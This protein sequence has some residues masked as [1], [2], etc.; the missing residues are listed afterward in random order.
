MKYIKLFEHFDKYDFKKYDDEQDN[1]EDIWISVSED[2]YPLS[3]DDFD[4]IIKNTQLGFKYITDRHPDKDKA[5]YNGLFSKY[6]I[7]YLGD[8][9]YGLLTEKFPTI[10]SIEIFDNIDPLID[11]LNVISTQEDDIMKTLKH[12]ESFDRHDFRIYNSDDFSIVELDDLYDSVYGNSVS[13]EDFDYIQKNI[14][15][16]VWRSMY[17]DDL[18]SCNMSPEWD[19]YNYQIFYLGDYCY[20]L[21]TVLSRMLQVKSIEIFD[22]IEPLVARI[23]EL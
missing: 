23:N 11:V 19:A 7:I 21:V 20:A 22:Q 17:M 12:W 3:K 16:E 2:M 14:G 15:F 8:Y 18:Y 5:Y 13:V 10:I 9:C 6:T 4:Y 1:L